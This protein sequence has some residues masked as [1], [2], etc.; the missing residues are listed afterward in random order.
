MRSFHPEGY[1]FIGPIYRTGC[2][3]PRLRI[4]SRRWRHGDLSQPT[5]IY[6]SRCW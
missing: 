6:T 5:P 3:A 4:E 1:P 2:Y